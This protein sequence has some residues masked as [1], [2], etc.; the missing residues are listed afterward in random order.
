MERQPFQVVLR[1]ED[2]G[3]GMP[4]K[5]EPGQWTEPDESRSFGVGLSG[6]RQRLRHV[7]GHLEIVS[8]SQGTTVTAVVPLG[9]QT[10]A[11]PNI[12]AKALEKR[13]AVRKSLATISVIAP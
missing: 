10:T 13:E 4:V 5:T 11:R 2:H 8:G 12:P 3:R 1:I 7:G 9:G 6:M